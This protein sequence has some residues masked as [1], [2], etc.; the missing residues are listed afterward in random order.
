MANETR[1]A[2]ADL[3]DSLQQD[4]TRY[5]FFQVMR[6]L[7][8]AHKDKF[9]FGQSQRPSHEPT[10][11]L[12]QDVSLTFESATLSSF[13]RLKTGLPLL[14]QRAFGLFGPNGPM[15]LHLTEYIHERIHHHRDHTLTG[16]VDI[17]HHRMICLFYRAWANTEPTVS[18]VRP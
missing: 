13:S 9:R 17:F 1:T 11:R 3:E 4:P 18:F 14:K 15:P 16:F 12:G 8:C 7:E 5:G 10:I 6:L 2:A